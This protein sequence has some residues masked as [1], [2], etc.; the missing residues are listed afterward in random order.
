MASEENS[1]AALLKKMKHTN[2]AP[3]PQPVATPQAV[4]QTAV[5]SYQT[6]ASRSKVPTEPIP[7]LRYLL[8]ERLDDQ[9]E[10]PE[11]TA[12][13]VWVLLSDVQPEQTDLVAAAV[14]TILKHVD[15]ESAECMGKILQFSVRLRKWIVSEH[16]K[17]KKSTLIPKMLKVRDSKPRSASFP[18]AP[19]TN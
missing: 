10:D 16:N 13:K 11:E 1:P 14:T 17:D 6:A 19:A 15:D 3:S 8:Q 9:D 2:D 4:L 7:R 18:T 12:N 5:Q